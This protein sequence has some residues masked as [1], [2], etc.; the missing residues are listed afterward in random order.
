[1]LQEYRNIINDIHKK[2][3]ENL[4]DFRKILVPNREFYY[5]NGDG[6]LVGQRMT[7]RILD[8]LGINSRQIVTSFV[9]N[10][11]NPGMITR[12]QDGNFFVELSAVYKND[13][14]SIGSIIAH[15]VTHMY[16]ALN[17]IN[18][19]DV[20]LN[21]K[22]TDITSILIGL[23]IIFLNGYSV[24]REEN[25]FTKIIETNK[26]FFGYL[27]PDIVGKL[28]AYYALVNGYDKQNIEKSLLP[29]GKG[30]FEAGVPDSLDFLNRYVVSRKN[31]KSLCKNVEKARNMI[32]SNRLNGLY[33][34]TILFDINIDAKL[35][36]KCKRC[37]QKIGIPLLDKSLIITCPVCKEEMEI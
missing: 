28:V 3:K 29:I 37:F 16:M 19:S 4:D 13:P 22:A 32:S 17:N 21:E 2:N 5:S 15:E 36:F 35:I 10:M 25:T 14:I 7:K 6:V 9:G 1:M 20:N 33:S 24:K 34:D 11:S 23:G 30:Y 31:I 27:S 8:Y 18:F 26:Q 12:D